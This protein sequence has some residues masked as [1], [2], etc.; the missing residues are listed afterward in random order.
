MEAAA[1][2]LSTCLSRGA[3]PPLLAKEM[4]KRWFPKLEK[5]DLERPSLLHMESLGFANIMYDP[6][7]R[8]ITGLLDYEDCIGGDPLF[9]I[10][11]MRF[12]FEHD[13]HDQRYFDVG[14]F[15]AGYGALELDSDR[16]AL[17]RPFTFLDKLRWI[18]PEGS[19]AK[20]YVRRLETFIKQC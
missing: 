16:I 10:C 19:R 9:E 11:W 12:Y 5:A 14:R 20:G 1:S 7:T 13:S 8:T 18:E 6:E 4:K 17:Y 2:A 3:V 15:A